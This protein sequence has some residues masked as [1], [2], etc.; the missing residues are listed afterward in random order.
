MDI[1]YIFHILIIHCHDISLENALSVL[2]EVKS[3][4][5]TLNAI[6]K[7][8]LKRHVPVIIVKG[9]GR[10][11]DFLVDVLERFSEEERIR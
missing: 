10:A 4:T 9:S 8:S 3:R 7:K 6:N 2:L 1:L 11:A 5:G